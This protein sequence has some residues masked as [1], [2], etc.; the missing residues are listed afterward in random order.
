MYVCMY[1]YVYHFHITCF[2]EVYY[3]ILLLWVIISAEEE[4]DCLLERKERRFFI[5]CDKLLYKCS[6][7][8]LLDDPMILPIIMMIVIISCLVF[9][10][11]FASNFHTKMTS[12][13]HDN[14]S[15]MAGVPCVSN[16]MGMRR[17]QNFF[18]GRNEIRVVGR[19][20]VDY[21]WACMCV[22]WC[23]I[24]CQFSDWL[25]QFC[26][27]LVFNLLSCFVLLWLNQLVR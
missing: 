22:M 8:C 20:R 9:F 14:K 11:C 17:W 26:F 23:L 7:S 12:T 25:D 21:C 10:S 1:Y 18:L 3:S 19:A 13:N 4:S 24:Q 5:P 27:A 15:Y 16:A 6:V 2:K